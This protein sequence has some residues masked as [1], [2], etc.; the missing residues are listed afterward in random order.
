MEALFLR[1]ICFIA[2]AIYL[3][4]FNRIWQARSIGWAERA[5]IF[6]AGSIIGI[7]VAFVSL[8]LAEIE[9]VLAPAG[10][11]AFLF[12]NMSFRE[13][14]LHRKFYIYR[15]LAMGCMFGFSYILVYSW[16]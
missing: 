14:H 10:F 16:L 2:I 12:E 1:L 7:P 3:S 9:L 6:L 5:Y 15:S 4:D 13:V 11:G 8:P